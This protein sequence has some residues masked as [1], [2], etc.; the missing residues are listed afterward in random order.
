MADQLKLKNPW[1]VAVW[2]GMGHVALNAGIYLLSKLEM[3]A[4]AEF[5]SQELFDI[6]QLEVK[7]GL[8]Q[9]GQRP[10]S[11]FFIRR[12]PNERHDLVLFLGEAQ[13]PVGKYAFCRN[14]VEFAKQLGVERVFT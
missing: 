6:E 12:D 9:P 10:R 4:F 11:R 7:G 5:G 1:L 8:I 14:V 13:P 3:R 2:P